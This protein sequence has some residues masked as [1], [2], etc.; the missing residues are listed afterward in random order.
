MA[1]VADFVIITHPDPAD[2]ANQP[3]GKWKSRV[4]ATGARNILRENGIELHNAYITMKFFVGKGDT[5]PDRLVRV[6]VNDHPLPQLAIV[7]AGTPQESRHTTAVTT[8]PASYLKNGGGNVVEL[9]ARDERSFG[10]LE[11]IVHFRQNS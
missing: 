3:Q 7:T 6:I 5:G 8:S 9:H 2:D 11:A 1:E 4:F 10:L